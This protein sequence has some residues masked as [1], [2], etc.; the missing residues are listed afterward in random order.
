M[1]DGVMPVEKIFDLKTNKVQYIISLYIDNS[2]RI[3]IGT[4]GQGLWMIEGKQL[5]HFTENDGLINNNVLSIS[6]KGNEIWLGTL[7]GASMFKYNDNKVTFNNFGASAGLKSQYV[8]SVFVWKD[9]VW[10]GTDGSGLIKYNNGEFITIASKDHLANVYSVVSSGNDIWFSSQGGNLNRLIG[11]SIISYPIK[12]KGNETEIS[13]LL[14]TDNDHVYYMSENGVGM[15][16]KKS[17]QYIVFDEEYGLIPFNY[18]YLNALSTDKKGNIWV[19]TEAFMLNMRMQNHKVSLVPQTYI[20]SVEVFSDIIDTNL[21]E[22]DATQNHFIFNYSGLWYHDPLK[23]RFKYRL[24][25]FDIHWKETKDIEAI[26][27]KLPPGSYTFEVGSTASAN[28]D[29]VSYAAYAFTIKKPFYYQWWFIIVVLSFTYLLSHFII[30]WNNQKNI[31]N[32]Q[33]EREK[34]LSQFELL[35][36]QV[37]PHFL[38]NSLNT[39]NAL[40]FKNSSEASDFLLKLSDYMRYLLTQ[41]ENTTHSLKEE[42]KLVTDYAYLQKKRFGNN[43]MIDIDLSDDLKENSLIPPLSIQILLENAIKHNI[44]SQSK[45]LNINIYREI[46]YLVVKNNLQEIKDK[47]ESTGIGLSNITSRYHI[48]FKKEIK[49]DKSED[50]FIVKLPIIIANHENITD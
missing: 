41:N 12:Y 40:I 22:F 23:V 48:L 14:T 36:S 18:N 4:F 7:G 26:Y 15:F 27:Q 8:Y 2:D 39:L 35:K 29:S 10:L 31:R 32:A 45:P 44:I 49:I 6:G 37:N 46:D 5:K 3:W 16:D 38:F 1:F 20:S 30:K 21:H 50:Y 34:I 24:K 47:I 33:I 11:D 19:G 13:T 25:G 9:D 43:L 42:L 17:N 28:F